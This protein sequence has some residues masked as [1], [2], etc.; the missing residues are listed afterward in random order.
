MYK[1]LCLFKYLCTLEGNYLEVVEVCLLVFFPKINQTSSTPAV[2]V[3]V[4]GKATMEL[5][6]VGLENLDDDNEVRWGAC[7]SSSATGDSHDISTL[8]VKLIQMVTPA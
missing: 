1:Y 5:E 3:A 6:Q 8:H 7:G 4:A 2:A